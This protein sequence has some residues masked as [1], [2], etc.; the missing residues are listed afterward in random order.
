MI[1]A[2]RRRKERKTKY[3]EIYRQRLVRS[4]GIGYRMYY[5]V[6]MILY[7][8][9]GRRRIL[10]TEDGSRLP[11]VEGGGVKPKVGAGGRRGAR[12]GVYFR[13][14]YKTALV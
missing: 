7:T 12:P 8:R 10:I 2:R 9:L 1:L 13:M 14:Q 3:R 6:C 5:K 11:K 4:A